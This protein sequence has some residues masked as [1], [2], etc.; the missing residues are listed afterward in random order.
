M[1]KI[2]NHGIVVKALVSNSRDQRIESPAA[3]KLFNF[4]KKVEN[5]VNRITGIARVQQFLYYTTYCY[6]D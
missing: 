2:L 6:P 5:R 1:N 4:P 3:Q